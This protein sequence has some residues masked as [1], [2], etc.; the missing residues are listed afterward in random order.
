M[1]MVRSRFGQI[2]HI[3]QHAA[4]VIVGLV[5]IVL[6]L[7]LTFSIVF[8][9]PGMIVLALGVAIVAGGIFAHS[10]AGP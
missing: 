9:L 10:V 2:V 6:G 7:A 8:S 3:F 5:L 4:V 1:D